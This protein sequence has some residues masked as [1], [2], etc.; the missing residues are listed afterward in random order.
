MADTSTTDVQTALAN[1]ARRNELKTR[2]ASLQGGANATAS[3]VALLTSMNSDSAIQLGQA[4]GELA[5]LEAGAGPGITADFGEKSS[6]T[7]MIENERWAAKSAVIDFV[8]LNPTCAEEAA[9]TVWNAAGVATH[10]D[11]PT[12]I[13]DGLVMSALYRGNLFSLGLIAE[14]TWEAH[15]DWIVATP[16]DTIMGL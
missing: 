4:Q 11:F 13:Q 9:D 8:K 5:A 2:I 12:C 1:E 7:Q 6:I 3:L 14:D 15:R 16:K 10:P